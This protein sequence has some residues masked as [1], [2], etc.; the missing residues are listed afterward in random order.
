MAFFSHMLTERVEVQTA[1]MD[2]ETGQPT[3]YSTTKTVDARVEVK[4]NNKNS[5]DA[6][7]DDIQTVVVSDEHIPE[8]ARIVLPSGE[9]ME[10]KT[11]ERTPHMFGNQIYHR[12][13]G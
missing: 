2:S 4:T 6:I 3:G 5:P 1:T 13:I 9:T 11:V 8:D 7:E 10:V 12:A